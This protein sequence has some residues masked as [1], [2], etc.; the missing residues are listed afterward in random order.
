MAWH[1]PGRNQL[2]GIYNSLDEFLGFMGRVNELSG[3]TFRMRLLDVN[4]SE[5]HTA[6]HQLVH[7]ERNGSALD[8]EVVHLLRW[9]NAKVIDGKGLIV[10]DGTYRYDEF[11]G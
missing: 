9:R 10:G 8:I 2:S 5:E 11:W 3:G 6:D 7:G 1:V 4:V